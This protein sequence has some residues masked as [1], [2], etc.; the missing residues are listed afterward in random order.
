MWR[1]PRRNKP[2]HRLRK[3]VSRHGKHSAPRRKL[4]ALPLEWARWDT[5]A[6]RSGLTWAEWARRILNSYIEVNGR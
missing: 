4:G 6:K 5:D 3:P 2:L 1:I